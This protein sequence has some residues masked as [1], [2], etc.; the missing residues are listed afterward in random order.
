MTLEQLRLFV[1]VVQAGSFTGA[2]ERLGTQ[3]SHA[4]RVVAQFEAALGAKLL[5]RTT[6]SLSLTEAGREVHARA[7]AIL[8]AV[9]DTEQAVQDMHGE[10]RGLLRLTCGV[11]FGLLTVNGWLAAFLAAYPRAAGEVE[12]TS[13]VVD[14]VHE[15]FDLAVRVGPLPA[16]TL[17]ARRLGTL[18]YGLYASPAHLADLSA[19][20]HPAGLRGRPLVMF[21]GGGLRQG[22]TLRHGDSGETLRIEGP[23]RLRVNNSL[24]VRDALVAG[25][26]IGLL[27][28]VFAAPALAE[29]RLRP[30]LPQWQPPE[31]P[32]HAVYPSGRYLAPKVRAFID[33]AVD[34]FP[35]AM[36]APTPAAAS[37]ARRPPAPPADRAPPPR[38]RPAPR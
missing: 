32:V 25:L 17:V 36:P 29:G 23:A 9:D 35:A 16:S 21:S 10:P 38:R 31:V 2:A 7:L 30:V 18:H 24:A 37:R 26:G 19:P 12:Y 4:S 27:P 20:D 28:Q 11:E 8:G 22:W 15:G 3:K 5:E 13:R 33:L 34:R 14:L 1:Q 6:R